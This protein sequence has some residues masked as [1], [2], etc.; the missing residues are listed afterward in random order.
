MSGTSEP[1]VG[2]S[3]RVRRTID[4]SVAHS[5][6]VHDY[7]LGGKDNFAAD[8]AAGDAVMAAYP[9]IV[10]SVRANR[11]FLARAV[12][13]LAAEAGIRQFLDIG[14]GIPASNNTHEVAQ[15]E[16]PEARVVYVDYDPVVLLHA[17]ALLKG[18]GEGALDYIDADLR[19]PQAILE[20]AAKTLDFSGPVAVMLIAIMHLIVDDDDP[21]GLVG[22]L[23][24]AVPAGS[25]L[26]LSQVASDIHAEQMAEAGRRYN[27]LARETQRHRT[28]AEVARFFDGLDL[29]EPGLVPVQ[30]WRPGSGSEAANSHSAMWGGVARKG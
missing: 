29:V 3:A 16:V 22:Q 18:S 19:N 20:Q 13:F 28:H 9:G 30:H 26:A 15:S 8:R 5:A 11:A 24:A 12:R 25:Y 7:W 14:T 21:Y 10:M 4:T 6:R 17:R 27:R 1:A 23:M 2:N